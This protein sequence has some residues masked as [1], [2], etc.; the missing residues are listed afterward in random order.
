MFVNHD[1]SHHLKGSILSFHYSIL[2]RSDERRNRA[3][4]HEFCRSFKFTSMINLDFYDGGNSF[5]F[6]FE[7]IGQ[8]IPLKLCF[9][10]SGILPM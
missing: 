4:F 5:H 9:N 6:E 3:L 10:V 7:Q 2:G 8:R 1:S